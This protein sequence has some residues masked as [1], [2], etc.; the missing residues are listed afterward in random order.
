MADEAAIT[1]V[2]RARDEA[3]AKMNNVTNAMEKQA[4]TAQ[5][6][7]ATLTATGGALTAVGSLMGQM[8]SP[9]A[10]LASTFMVTAGAILSTTGAILAA[11]PMIRQLITTLRSL[12]I[13]QALVAALSGPAGWGT[14]AIGLALAGGAAAAI[15]GI[16][17]GFSGGG[18][19]S[20]SAQVVN[21]N[22]PV[23][24]N[25]ADARRFSRRMQTIQREE[26]RLGR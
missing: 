1:I 21:I 14:L 6:L 26:T 11:L 18:S 25:D 22:G 19:R 5:N 9:A 13:V 4:L 20:Q 23:M 8:E 17:G 24:G 15:Y 16:S 10:K 7:Q 3:S 2:T 12:A